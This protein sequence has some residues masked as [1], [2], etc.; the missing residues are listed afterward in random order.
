M[1]SSCVLKAQE[2]E[3]A[4]VCRKPLPT[5][6]NIIAHRGAYKKNNTPHNSLAAFRDAIALRLMAIECD[7]HITADDSVVVYHDAVYNGFAIHE[8]TYRQLKESGRLANGEELPLFDDFVKTA[9]DGRY[10]SIW[11]DVKLHSDKYGGKEVTAKV[12]ITCMSIARK[13][14]ANHFIAFLIT[15]EYVLQQAITAS[16][17]DF[18]IAYQSSD[19]PSYY[20]E[21]GYM[22]AN[23]RFSNFYPDNEEKIVEFRKCGVRVTS[24]LANQLDIMKWFVAHSDITGIMSDDPEM[25]LRVIRGEL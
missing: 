24:Y 8:S 2:G 5:D 15:D 14:N 3:F 10:T 16:S 12:C 22:W 25:L 23:Q 17:G 13:L 18:A 9:L 19:S 7:V 4:D 1:I 20:Q 21:K 6:N 11:V